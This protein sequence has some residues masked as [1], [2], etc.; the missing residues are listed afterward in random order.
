MSTV[1]TSVHSI[2]S[3]SGADRWSVCIGSLA[4]TRD[5]PEDRTNNKPA[6]L[7]SAK[8][9]LSQWCIDHGKTAAE[10]AFAAKFTIHADGHDFKVDEEFIGHVQFALDVTNRLPGQ[11]MTEVRLDTSEVLGVAGQG[12]TSDIV[13]IDY[14]TST[15]TVLDYKFGWGRVRA[16]KNKQLMIYL[17][18]ARKRFGG[19]FDFENF[20]LVIV[21]PALNA[22][23]GE[24]HTYT[25]ADLDAFEKEIRPAAVLAYELYI[26][27]TP[28]PDER[29]DPMG[30]AE[31]TRLKLKYAEAMGMVN[32]NLHPSDKGC[33]WCPIAGSCAART[34][35]ITDQ[36]RDVSASA[37]APVTLSDAELG[38]LAILVE[39]T[40]KPFMAEVMSE[41]YKRALSGNDPKTLQWGMYTGRDGHRR[42]IPE[43]K[44]AIA[45]TLEMTLGDDMWEERQLKSPTQIEASLKAAKAHALYAMVAPYVER[46]PGK[47]SLQRFRSDVPPA[48]PANMPEFADVTAAATV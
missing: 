11:K 33:E 36:F 12:G 17:C 5:I 1:E 34:K 39:D 7:G 26:A 38:K 40:M 4:A 23:E 25:A 14:D 45:T 42:F 15:L 31:H 41:L 19:L 27:A 10:G 37:V 21:Q 9:T 35:R 28:V 32:A 22:V 24:D 8:H 43:H 47:P 6:A 46:P 48:A 30:A 20:K 2:L 18:A 29:V 16:F 13:V 44:E 3:P